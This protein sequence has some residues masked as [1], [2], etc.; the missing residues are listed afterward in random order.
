MPLLLR[1]LLAAAG[2]LTEAK[3]RG[4][5]VARPF[6]QGTI[7]AMIEGPAPCSVGPRV[8]LKLRMTS[9][10]PDFVGRKILPS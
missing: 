1:S 4:S 8:A 2:H 9:R 7:E 10:G 3:Y 5:K 6:D